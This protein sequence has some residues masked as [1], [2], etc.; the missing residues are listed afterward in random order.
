MMNH[1]HFIVTTRQSKYCKG[2]RTIWILRSDGQ[3]WWEL[4]RFRVSA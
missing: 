1:V 2:C 3:G 4:P